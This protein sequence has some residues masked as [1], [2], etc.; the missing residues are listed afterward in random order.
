MSNSKGIN[1]HKETRYFKSARSQAGLKCLSRRLQ[2]TELPK[3]ICQIFKIWHIY[4]LFLGCSMSLHAQNPHGENLKMDC[5]ACHNADGWEIAMD[6]W[7]FEDDPK[8]ELSQATGWP[9]GV[10]TAKFNHYNTLFPLNGQH[11]GVDCRECHE[12][13]VFEE[14]ST[15]CISCHVDLHRNTVG[16]DCARCHTEENWLVDNITELHQENGFPLLGVH[17]QINCIE[18]HESETGLE[19]NRIGNE[20]ISCHLE[21]FNATTDPNH[22]ASGFSLECTDCHLIEGFDWSSEF[23]NHDFFPLVKGHDI[24]DCNACH[25]NGDFKNTPTDCV[26]CH[27]EDFNNAQVPNHIASDFST[28]CVECHTLDVDWMPA[29][30]LAHDN[31]FPIYSGS[32]NGEWDACVDCHLNPNDFSEFT[33][34]TCHERNETDND[35]DD[36]NG[37]VYSSPACLACHPTGNEDDNFD[38]NRTRFPLRGAHLGV[39]CIE[40]HANGYTGTPTDCVAC[41]TSDFNNAKDPDHVAGGFSMECQVCHSEEAWEPAIFNHDATEFPLRGAH[42]QVDCIECHADGYEG[43][44]TDCAACHQEDYDQTTN[45]NHKELGFGTDCIVCHTETAWI[46]ATFDH[47]NTNFPL[48]GAHIGVDCIECHADGYAGTPTDCAACHQLDFDNAKSPDHQKL[49]LSSDCISCH[50]TDPNWMPAS[51]DIHDQFYPLNGAHAAIKND[52]AACHN[53]TFTNTPTECIGCHQNDFDNA[54]DPNHRSAGFPTDCTECHS[55]VAWEPANFDHDGMY[56]PIYSGPHQGEWQQ[57]I[58]CHTTPGD[59]KAFSCIECHEHND[60]NDLRDEH[61]GVNGYKYESNACYE[62]HPRGESD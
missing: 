54:R 43:T 44:P 25:T 1:K 37:Y 15:D 29:E 57:C 6:S 59:F 56:F 17:A 32:H 45:P 61:D 33:C 2:T 21:D 52:C 47:N 46:P 16:S 12:N 5:K 27:Q 14:A 60:P 36:V 31:L 42:A 10:D 23:I 8:I 34:T 40:C 62:C 49:G 19:F 28:N 39:D 13:L 51:F 18:C 41:H 24:S 58:E 30:Y 50:T 7:N 48:T 55:E 4:I 53:S 26:A 22:I 35:H 38:H 11:Q 20:C 9:L 3:K